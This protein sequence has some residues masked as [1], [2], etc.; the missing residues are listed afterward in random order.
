MKELITVAIQWLEQ[1]DLT[2]TSL[3]L[4][5]FLVPRILNRFGIPLA[6]GAFA[7]G[8]VFSL[9]ASYFQAEQVVPTFAFLGIVSLF[10]FAGLE[11]DLDE[12]KARSKMLGTLMVLRLLL[13]L[14]AAWLVGNILQIGPAA[15]ILFAL[16]VVTPSAGFI[17]DSLQELKIA[18]EQ[19][20]LIKV[21]A[22]SS[23]LIALGALVLAQAKSPLLGVISLSAILVIALFLPKVFR[24]FA[25]G[26]S[27]VSSGADFTFLLLLAVLLGTI[28]KKM[29]AYYLVGAFIVGFALRL[30]QRSERSG[31]SHELMSAVRYFSAFFMPFYFFYAGIKTGF[32][33]FT[34]SGILIG[35]LLALVIAPFRLFVSFAHR[36]FIL[37]EASPE[38]FTVS[39]SLLPT[40][41]FGL[42][43][44]DILEDSYQIPQELIAG[45]TVYTLLVTTLP[46]LILRYTLKSSAYAEI[47]ETDSPMEF[48]LE[49]GWGMGR[50][51]VMTEKDPRD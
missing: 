45:L 15:S 7:I 35:V 3:I 23:E 38:A 8:M 21:T 33:V 49:H 20:D 1:H 39:T 26:A 48:P 50:G 19:K 34:G 12:L 5:L 42:V 22:I 18:P 31:S 46:P 29:G 6:V 51:R 36:K 11:V 25:T 28:T 4:L 17:L 37:K 40:L 16:A 32:S 13:I 27:K 41:V 44:I 43:L 30:Y 10:A 47:A 14:G 9:E 24:L 2:S